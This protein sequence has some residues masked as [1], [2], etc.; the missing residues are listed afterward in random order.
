MNTNVEQRIKRIVSE[1]TGVDESK[2]S[3][4]TGLVQDLGCDSLDMVELV[5]VVE[6]EFELD[7]PDE[8]AEAIQTVG[9][10]IEYVSARVP[11][12]LV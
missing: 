5:M 2:L 1:Q 8:E 7:I 12:S 11:Q 9:Q 4:E 6:D 10:A 3:A